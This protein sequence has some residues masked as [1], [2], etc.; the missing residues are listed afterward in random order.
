MSGAVDLAGLAQPQRPPQEQPPAGPGGIRPVVAVG[1][2][3]FEA[4]VLQRSMQ[5]P[6][7]VSIGAAE[8]PQS[9]QLDATLESAAVAAAGRWVLA[10]VDIH[11]APRIA[12]AFGVQ[13]V[14]TVLAVAA[15][16]PVDAFAGVISEA[17]LD[18]WI[19]GILD[20]TAGQLSGPPPAEGEEPAR[21]PRLVAAEDLMDAGDLPGSIQAYENILAEEPGNEEA[22]AAVRQLRFLVRAQDVPGDAVDAA[23][24]APGDVDKQLRAADA[25]LLAQQP[26]AAFGRLIAVVRT[27]APEDKATARARLLELFDLFDPAEEHVIRARR[28]LANALY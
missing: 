16:R 23:D 18:Q 21:D 25:Q 2:A 9:V 10:T 8:Y 22:G 7:I 4:E 19:S 12:Q 26:D 15:G 28:D 27:G 24:A 17:E 20:A 1:E 14:P 11:N 5:V 6:V 3:D 13:S